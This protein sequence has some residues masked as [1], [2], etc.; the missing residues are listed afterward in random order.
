MFVRVV[1]RLMSE[2]LA[3]KWKRASVDVLELEGHLLVNQAIQLVGGGFCGFKEGEHHLTL[4]NVVPKLD[5][6]ASDVVNEGM[7]CL[8]D[9]CDSLYLVRLVLGVEEIEFE[10]EVSRLVSGVL[11]KVNV[12]G[13][14][15]GKRLCV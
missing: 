11:R 13:F 14:G 3:V 15:F 7:V 6:A 8:I 4:P 12:N 9:I 1:I 2:L 5:V 10:G